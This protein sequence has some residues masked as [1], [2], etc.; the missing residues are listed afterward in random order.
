[1][2]EGNDNN[3]YMLVNVAEELVKKKVKEMMPSYDMCQCTKCYLDVCAL[4]LNQT[5]SRYY[6]T[7]KGKLLNLLDMT[8]YQFKTDL[9]V[10]VL[11]A[12]KQVKDHPRH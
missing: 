5:H 4:V 11:S 10:M 12:M 3:E 6:T 8:D 2:N 9:L 1:M 7:E